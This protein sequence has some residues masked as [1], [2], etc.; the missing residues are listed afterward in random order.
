MIWTAI[1]F[2]SLAAI[3]GMFLLSYILRNKPTP[4]GVAFIHGPFAAVGII[5]LII[6]SIDHAPKPIE[7]IILFIIA[8]V[9]GTILIY[10]DLTGNTIPKWLAIG[11]G[12]IA[13]VGFSFLLLF[14]FV[15]T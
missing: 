3:L 8:A 12:L 14:A 9:G 11:H 7:S 15:P 1:G 4:K 6:Y 5:L 13:V 10:R 2:F